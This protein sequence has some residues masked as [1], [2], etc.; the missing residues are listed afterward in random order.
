MYFIKI[1]G[2]IA[3]EKVNEFTVTADSCFSRWKHLCMDVVFSK[4]LIYSDLCHYL[5]TWEN[6][7]SYKDFIQS[8]DYQVLYGCFQVPG[9]ITKVNM[10]EMSSNKQSDEY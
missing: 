1:S 5:S 4:D 7:K 3:E 8:E 10:G 2:F 6:E 9:S